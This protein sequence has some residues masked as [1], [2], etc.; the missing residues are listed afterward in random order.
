MYSQQTKARF[1][2]Y[3]IVESKR[4]RRTGS[5]TGTINF[6]SKTPASTILPLQQQQRLKHINAIEQ[7]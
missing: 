3:Q 7:L 4:H 2:P 1:A 6:D 5:N